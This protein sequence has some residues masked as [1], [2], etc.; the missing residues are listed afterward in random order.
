MKI[1]SCTFHPLLLSLWWHC[2][3]HFFTSLSC[4]YEVTLWPVRLCRD[5]F[6]WGKC[7]FCIFSIYLWLGASVKTILLQLFVHIFKLLTSTYM[8]FVSPPV[9][10]FYFFFLLVIFLVHYHLTHPV[11]K[12]LDTLLKV[13]QILTNHKSG[14]SFRWKSV[15]LC[16][17]SVLLLY[18]PLFFMVM[19]KAF[20]A[21]FVVS[22]KS[23]QI[24]KQLLFNI[25]CQ[26]HSAHSFQEPLTAGC[27]LRHGHWFSSRL[28]PPWILSWSTEKETPTMH[29]VIPQILYDAVRFYPNATR[30]VIILVFLP[31]AFQQL[32]AIKGSHPKQNVIPAC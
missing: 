24:W 14:N 19:V 26:L 1:F 12:K 7:C 30:P 3:A 27:R 17:D 31:S 4:R 5:F 28:I 21:G 29:S 11:V 10:L 9:L 15:S 8:D 13:K 18:S 25:K 22:F 6:S 16:E 32:E 20:Y 23:K 2:I